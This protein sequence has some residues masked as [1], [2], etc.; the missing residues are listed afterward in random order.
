MRLCA[1]LVLGVLISTVVA[2]SCALYVEGDQGS[3]MSFPEFVASD[4]PGMSYERLESLRWP[5]SVPSSWEPTPEYAG[6]RVGTGLRIVKYSKWGGGPGH[7]VHYTFAAGWPM[8]SHSAMLFHEKPRDLSPGWM[9]RMY[10]GRP[11]ALLNTGLPARWV[12]GWAYPSWD[13][14]DNEFEWRR[15]PLTPVWPGFIVNALDYGAG[16]WVLVGVV[17]ALRARRR[18]RTGRCVAC[19]YRRDSLAPGAPCP[20]CGQAPRVGAS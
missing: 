19:G 13:D 17:S 15:I 11:L 8:R 9:L 1:S 12:P 20:E 16:G 2:W 3:W 10:K 6:R 7:Q 14:W 18:V 5:E 4:S